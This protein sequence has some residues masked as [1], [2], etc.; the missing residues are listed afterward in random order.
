MANKQTSNKITIANIVAMVGIVLLG[1]FTFMGHSYLSGGELAWDVIVSLAVVS[2]TSLLLWLLIRAKGAENELDKWKKTEYT[3]LGIYIIFA[4]TT[5]IY[6][7]TMHFFIVNGFKGH[8]FGC[9]IL[10]FIHDFLYLVSYYF[11]LHWVFDATCR[12][13]LV[14]S[15]GYSL[16]VVRGLLIAAASLVAEHWP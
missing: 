4:I 13:S 8:P 11:W 10:L 1:I 5:S 3:T 12:L 15:G 14:A 2:V 6:C 7:G 16:G 9:C